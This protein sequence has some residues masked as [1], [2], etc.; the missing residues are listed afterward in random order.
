M[1]RKWLPYMILPSFLSKDEPIHMPSREPTFVT[2]MLDTRHIETISTE[3]NRFDITC[4]NCSNRCGSHGTFIPWMLVAWFPLIWRYLAP[5][6]KVGPCSLRRDRRLPSDS[7][8]WSSPEYLGGGA[9]KRWPKGHRY[10]SRVE[11]RHKCYEEN[12]HFK[13]RISSHVTC[14]YQFQKHQKYVSQTN[15]QYVSQMH[16]WHW[17]IFYMTYLSVSWSP[18][19]TWDKPDAMD[20]NGK[21]KNFQPHQRH[22]NHRQSD[23]TPM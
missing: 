17:Q 5:S 11:N 4:R 9:K 1:N 13:E 22:Q 16:V 19:K 21:A 23:S 10:L 12:W 20:C 2:A 6:S 3:R 7:L 18:T 14:Q 15:Q 8:V